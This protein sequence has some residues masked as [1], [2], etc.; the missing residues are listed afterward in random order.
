MNVCNGIGS[1]KRKKVY[2]RRLCAQDVMM[3]RALRLQ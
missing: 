1:E 2:I 3:E